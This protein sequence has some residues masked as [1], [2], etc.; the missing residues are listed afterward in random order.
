MREGPLLLSPLE[1]PC[2]KRSWIS[3]KMRYQ[4][5]GPLTLILNK[6][7]VSIFKSLAASHTYFLLF[8]HCLI[9]S[10]H[11]SVQPEANVSNFFFT[12]G[13]YCWIFSLLF[14]SDLSYILYL[15]VPFL[16]VYYQEECAEA[17]LTFIV[18]TG[19]PR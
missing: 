7:I 15:N 17:R 3:Q 16:L 9:T 5:M 11:I 18:S 14:Y 19:A 2:G 1:K 13:S 8:I 4:R 12:I 10:F 6:G